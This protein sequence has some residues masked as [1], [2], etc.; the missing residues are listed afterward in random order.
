MDSRAAITN[1]VYGY[2]ERIDDG[3]FEGVAEI[4][5]HA[6]VTADG[7]DEVYRG[8]EAVLGMYTA[9]TRR[10]EDGTPLTKHVTTNLIIEVDEDGG[11]ATGRSY[12]TV[13]QAVPGALALQPV[14]AGRYHDS[15][16]RVDGTWRFS[17]RRMIVDL[18]GDLS[19]HLLY[20]L[21]D[22]TGGA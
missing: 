4:L 9:A 11:R 20:E 13:M 17:G 1:L 2:A 14:I 6:E 7:N 18:V 10:Y 5:R 19:R 22:R 3:D 16:E 15:F 21:P 8:Y 12:F